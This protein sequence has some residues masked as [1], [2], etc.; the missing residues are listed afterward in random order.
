MTYRPTVR[1][2]SIYQDYVNEVNN[3]TSLDR[4]QIFRL[5][6]FI[7]AH[8]KEYND[9]LKKYQKGDVPLPCPAWRIDEEKCWQ[10]QSYIKKEDTPQV[11]IIEQGGI[12]LIIG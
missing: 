9:I 12:K 10:E 8:S 2:P 11:K 5:A 3:A 1:Y 4:N 6:L 7:A